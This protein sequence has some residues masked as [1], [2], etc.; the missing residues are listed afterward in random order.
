MRSRCHAGVGTE[1]AGSGR[2]SGIIRR[3]QHVA[4]T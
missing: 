1:C 2:D 3:D 4:S